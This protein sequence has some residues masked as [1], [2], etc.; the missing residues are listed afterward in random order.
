MIL[1]N[2]LFVMLDFLLGRLV[3]CRLWIR[4]GLA[5]FL[6][7]AVQAAVGPVDFSAAKELMRQHVYF[8][9]NIGGQLG[10][11][12]CGCDWQWAGR[13]G[14]VIDQAGCGYEVRAL[15]VQA[16]RIEWEHIVP[17]SHFGFQR[18]CWQQGGRSACAEQ[19]AVFRLMEADMHN[20]SP[21][22]GE[23][24]ADRSSYRFGVV[25][26]T[27][28]MYGRCQSKTDFDQRVFEP[29]DAVKGLVA[30]VTF[31]MHDRYDLH[32]SRQ[33]Q[34][35]LMAWDRAYPVSNWELERNRRIALVMGHDN[36]F[37]TGARRWTLGQRNSGQG[38][39]SATARQAEIKNPAVRGNRNSRIYHLPHCP[40]YAAV[41][42][43][44]AVPFRS[45]R[46][47][48]QAGFRRAGNC[49]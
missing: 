14:G 28:G 5:L 42:Q 9:Q 11:L 6:S 13:S 36:P 43:R 25:S 2:S 23:V 10:T 27:A 15:P 37:V 3:V 49:K 8:D 46:E 19:D 45:E 20:L 4:L 30:R 29:R 32:M 22:V 18:Q 24:N 17:A 39:G 41:S 7:V 40:S 38:V 48:Q 1:K 26:G 31:Y 33:Q 21:T 47:A 16:A 12:Y 44:N 35:L 34:Q